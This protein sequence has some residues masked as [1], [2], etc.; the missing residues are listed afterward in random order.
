MRLVLISLFIAFAVGLLSGGRFSGLSSLKIRWAPLAVIGFGLQFFT[1]SARGWPY[2][3]LVLSFI[4]LT[5][6]AV[7]NLKVAGFTLILAGMLMNFAVIAVNHGMP[8]TRYA[9]SASGQGDLLNYLIE[10]GGAKHHLAGPQDRLIILA[11]VAPIPPPVTQAVS[12]G[13]LVAYAGVG[14]VVVAAMRRGRRGSESEAHET[15]AGEAGMPE[16]GSAV[17]G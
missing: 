2:V 12:A 17:G 13:D 9:L 7:V 5:V 3:L 14:Y 8:V 6:F 4:L 1:P 15:E 10:Q 11:D 16:R